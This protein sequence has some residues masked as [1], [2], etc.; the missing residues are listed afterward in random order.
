MQ[1][2]MTK[3]Q[4]ITVGLGEVCGTNDLSI[5]LACFGLGSCVSVCA[6][7]PVARVAGMT[8]IVLPESDHSNRDRVSAKYADI[9]VPMLLEGMYKNGALKRNLVVKLVGGAQML[10][11]AG[12]DDALEMGTRNVETTKRV[13]ANE[14]VHPSATDTG[15]SQGRSV[16][17]SVDSGKV[18]VRTAGTELKEL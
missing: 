17:L 12:F 7:D 5:V 4:T 6:Y 18:M 1:M 16:W 11:A 10:Q 15:G 3:E 14:G 8:H 9:A 13:L 2:I